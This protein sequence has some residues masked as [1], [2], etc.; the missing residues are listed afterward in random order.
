LARKARDWIVAGG[1]L[2]IV[3]ALSLWPLLSKDEGQH[4]DEHD[5]LGYTTSGVVVREEESFSSDDGE[6][7]AT[8]L[9][10]PAP[11]LNHSSRADGHSR[12]F[13]LA[14][15]A[16]FVRLKEFARAQQ[17]NPRSWMNDQSVADG[18]TR[19]QIE[20]LSRNADFIESHSGS[21]PDEPLSI[22][23]AIVIYE[24]ALAEALAGNV[25]AAR[26]FL[27]APWTAAGW[28]DSQRLTD[29]YVTNSSKMLDVALH[30]GDWPTVNVMI[31]T[32]AAPTNGLRTLAFSASPVDAYGYAR[33][34]QLGASKDDPTYYERV[35]TDVL[36]LRERL[37]AEDIIAMDEW[38]T[39]VHNKHFIGRGPS[40]DGID[41]PF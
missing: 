22:N 3:G 32:F 35:R 28:Q 10:E 12:Y 1:A 29:I 26:C 31:E 38:A 16:K 5:S 17:R 14:N 25:Q 27:Y 40:R 11:L 7:V 13:H 6:A 2:A 34:K 39:A 24:Q 23:R 33:L 9:S 21:C 41:C 15:C 18:L 20:A 36:A 19:A 4:D 37:V 30:S 8:V